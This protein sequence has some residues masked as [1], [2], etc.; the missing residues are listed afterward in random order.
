[1]NT[2]RF[3]SVLLA[4]AFLAA[5]PAAGADSAPA[6]WSDIKDC[7]YDARAQFIAGLKRLEGRVD[8]EVRELT[9]QRAAMKSSTDTKDWDFAMKEMM[10]SQTYL[11]SMNEELSKVTPETW[12]QEKDAVDKAW[13]RTQEAYDAVKSATTG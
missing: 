3:A 2:F 13:K 11:N 12:D 8:A 7:T 10:E 9:T 6:K 4:T 1:M 5:Y